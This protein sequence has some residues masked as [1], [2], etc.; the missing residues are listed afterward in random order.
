MKIITAI[1]NPKI[2]EELKKDNFY[3]V[4]GVDIQYQEGIFEILEKNKNIDCLILNFNLIGNLDKYELIEKIKEKNIKLKILIILEKE[5][6]KLIN[7]LFSKNIKN[8]IYE[9]EFNIKKINNILKYQNKKNKKIIKNKKTINI[10]L[11]NKKT[12]NKNKINELKNNIKIK[13]EIIKS[14]YYNKIKKIKINL[15]NKKINN[16]RNLINNKKIISIIG[17]KKSGKTIFTI[18]I[19]KIINKKVLIISFIKNKEINIMLGIKNNEEENFIKIN[20][21]IKLLKCKPES[22]IRK[23][24]QKE[25][26]KY[27]YIFIDTSNLEKNNLEKIINITD[28]YILILEPN[29]IGI[30]NSKKIIEEIFNK[31]IKNKNKIKIIINKN[32]CFSIDEKIIKYIFNK[33]KLIGTINQNNKYNFLINKNFKILDLKI[34]KEYLKIIK[35]V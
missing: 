30:N 24:L 20:N 23:D 5:N 28:E 16:K 2:N 33:F 21:K 35:E 1:G 34:K 3:D 10:K 9:N 17:D 7:Y 27:N 12:K 19:S 29:L 4:I 26:K 13:K 11:K 6:K 14:N 22:L 25:L 8:I 18:L 31:K 32:N 15:K